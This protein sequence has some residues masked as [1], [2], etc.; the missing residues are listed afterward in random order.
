M[1]SQISA[2]DVL[3]ATVLREEVRRRETRKRSP[4]G[5]R[6]L[7]GEGEV[8][9]VWKWGTVGVGSEKSRKVFNGDHVTYGIVT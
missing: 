1:S 9:E 6:G 2:Q 8:Q 4:E 7:E 5:G 3:L